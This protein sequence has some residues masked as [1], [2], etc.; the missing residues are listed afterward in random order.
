MQVLKKSHFH[1]SYLYPKSKEEK[2]LKYCIILKEK[3]ILDEE[4]EYG[5]SQRYT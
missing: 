3:N 5:I 4:K 2:K 1:C